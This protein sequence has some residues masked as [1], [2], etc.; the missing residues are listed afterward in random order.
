MIIAAQNGSPRIGIVAIGRNE[1]ERLRRCLASIDIAPAPVV[2]VDSA[3]TDGSAGQAAATGA[4]VVE[5]DVSVPFTAARA[6]NAGLAVL[7]ER[8]PDVEY[9]QFIDGDCE[10]ERGWIAT[11]AHFLDEHRDVAVV[12]GR[13]RE[14]FP[15]ASFYNRICD[16]EWNT[17]VGEATACGG[18][19][20]IRRAPL[21]SVGGYD[22][23]LSAG[24]E[25]ELCHRLRQ[26]GWR[27]WRLDAPMTIHDAA[28][29][30]F[31]QWWLR[32]VRSGMGYAQAWRAT[33]GRDAPLYRRE[34]LRA[35]AWT[36]GVV[37]IGIIASAAWGW[38]AI[39]LAPLIWGLQFLRLAA[40][41]GIDKAAL[42]LIGKV[43]ESVGIAVYA[44]RTVMGYA[45]GTIFYK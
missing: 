28:M 34:C 26:R 35:L 45:G 25:P 39:L 24:E 13:R 33:A 31:R 22:P 10:F 7:V 12:C 18:D 3:S 14:R 2:Y 16:A 5:L 43:A 19:A 4:I 44:C 40:R 23:A 15:D 9:V 41:H 1:G 29:Y 8:Y 27:I 37:A 20:L 11:A 42:L 32:A 21:T 30:R 38:A 17:R 36:V 6:R